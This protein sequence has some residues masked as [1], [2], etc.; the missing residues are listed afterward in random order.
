MDSSQMIRSLL[1]FALF[2]ACLPAEVQTDFDPGIDFTRFK[3]YCFIKGLELEKNGL[4]K[5]PE[6]RE[7]FKNLIAG[8]LDPRGLREVPRD[9]KY[10]LA[11]RYWVALRDK[12]SVTLEPSPDFG[13]AGWGGYPPYWTGPW[14][15][16]YEEYVVRNYQEGTLIIDLIDPKTKELVWRT[17][18]R[19]DLT[20]RIKAYDKVKTELAK[21]FA[22]FPPADNDR[23][24]MKR[25]KD[26]LAEKYH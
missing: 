9:E 22:K 3:T 24:H 14:G 10:D 13:W 23:D 6:V 1:L 2:T 20:D 19:E 17:F 21:S 12:Q 7:R 18:V 5:D 26:R 4:L 11:V 8:V 25:E 16:Y 15:W